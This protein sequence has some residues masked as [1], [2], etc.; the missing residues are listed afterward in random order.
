MSRNHGNIPR[1]SG[2]LRRSSQ[3]L[4]PHPRLDRTSFTLSAKQ[5]LSI[6]FGIISPPS[7]NIAL[8]FAIAC[9][10]K[11]QMESARNRNEQQAE[12][13]I[14]RYRDAPTSLRE[15]APNSFEWV[16]FIPSELVCPETEALFERWETMAFWAIGMF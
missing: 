12:L 8:K 13:K 4:V 16:V 6:E 1:H 2:R 11:N 15:L 10:G 14:W 3:Q 9:K 7:P 5:I